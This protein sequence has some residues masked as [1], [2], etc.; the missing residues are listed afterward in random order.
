MFQAPSRHRGYTGEQNQ[1]PVLT[2]LPL[3]WDTD[4]SQYKT[5]DSGRAVKEA[6]TGKRVVGD[7]VARGVIQE[8]D[9]GGLA[10]AA[11]N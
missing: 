10:R 9:D 8:S 3:W 4:H 2:E 1:V 7:V 5:P 6:S 11:E